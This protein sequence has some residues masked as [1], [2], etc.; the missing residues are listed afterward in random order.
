MF[1]QGALLHSQK[2]TL[3]PHSRSWILLSKTFC[4]SIFHITSQNRVTLLTDFSFLSCNR[5]NFTFTFEFKSMEFLH[6]IINNFCNYKSY[7]LIIWINKFKLFLLSV[8]LFPKKTFP[9]MSWW[10]NIE[11]FWVTLFNF[12]I[13]FMK[14]SCLLTLIF[15]RFSLGFS[16]IQLRKVFCLAIVFPGQNGKVFPLLFFLV[17]NVHHNLVSNQRCNHL[18]FPWFSWAVL[19]RCWSLVQRS[20]W[21]LIIVSRRCVSHY[22]YGHFVFLSVTYFEIPISHYRCRPIFDIIFKY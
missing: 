13:S 18:L 1:W 12:F 4:W 8:M 16:H 5:Y 9:W 7:L 11:R 22:Y 15:F 14:P 2:Q 20:F 17:G 6:K 3:S 19:F 10:I 21:L